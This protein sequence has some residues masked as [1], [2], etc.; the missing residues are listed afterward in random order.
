MPLVDFVSVGSN[1]LMQFL[2]A[3][4]RSNPKLVDRYDPLSPSFLNFLR[5]VV[6]QC[7][8]HGKLLTLCGEMGSRPIEAMALLGIGFERLSMP[9][10]A[11]G[12]VKEMLRSLDV[13]LLAEYMEGL[14]HLPDHSLRGR[15]EEFARENGVII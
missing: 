7:H 11:I 5:W 10:N 2:F 8:A 9:A 1:D 13:L 6:Q 14:Y 15:L 12:P 4:D 3:A